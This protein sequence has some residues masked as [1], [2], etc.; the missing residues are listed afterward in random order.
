MFCVFSCQPERLYNRDAV[1]QFNEKIA[2]GCKNNACWVQ[3]PLL[4]ASELIGS[5]IAARE[6][7]IHVEM[8]NTGE[9]A[10]QVKITAQREGEFDD[11]NSGSNYVFYMEKKAGQWQVVK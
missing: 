2:E 4:I 7:T 1:R 3:S 9:V 5:D 10:R 6:T 8:L 11:S